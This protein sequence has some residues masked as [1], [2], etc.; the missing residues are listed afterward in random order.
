MGFGVRKGITELRS[1]VKR[2]GK[3]SA[4]LHK[5]RNIN[6]DDSQLYDSLDTFSTSAIVPFHSRSQGF[7][8]FEQRLFATIWSEVRYLRRIPE[9]LP[10]CDPRN[11]FKSDN[12][13]QNRCNAVHE[14]ADPSSYECR[15]IAMHRSKHAAP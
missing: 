3:N 9:E 15:G 12:T 4:G 6:Y 10:P 2:T 11:L 13:E 7:S 8:E 5:C 1:L 14:H